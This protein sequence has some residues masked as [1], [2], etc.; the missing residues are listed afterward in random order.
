MLM[1]FL[2]LICQFMFPLVYIIIL[3]LYVVYKLVC[4]VTLARSVHD[5]IVICI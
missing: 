5:T 3:L 4:L 1:F 2:K